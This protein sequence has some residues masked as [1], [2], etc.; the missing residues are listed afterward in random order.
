MT[1][2]LTRAAA[3][4]L[5]GALL[6]PAAALADW[7]PTGIA[8]EHNGINGPTEAGGPILTTPAGTTIAATI[9]GSSDVVRLTTLGSRVVRELPD[10][11]GSAH[12]AT[13]GRNGIAVAGTT[14]KRTTVIRFGSATGGPLATHTFPGRFTAATDVAGNA[15]GDLAVSMSFGGVWLRRAHT[16]TFRQVF[17]DPARGSGIHQLALGPR[18]DLMLLSKVSNRRSG[19]KLVVRYRTA[20]GTW[21]APRTLTT[22]TNE[23]GLNAS[24]ALDSAGRQL[25]AWRNGAKISFASALAGGAVSAP[26]TLADDPALA[27]AD[28]SSPNAFKAGSIYLISDLVKIA[29]AEDGTALVAWTARDGDRYVIRAADVRN[30]KLTTAQTLTAAGQQGA[31]MDV[32]VRPGGRAIVLAENADPAYQPPTPG[33]LAPTRSGHLAVA[34]VRP[35]GASAFGAAETVTDPSGTPAQYGKVAGIATNAALVWAATDPGYNSFAL[36]RRPLP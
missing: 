1:S 6:A 32:A 16:T 29:S 33:G 35:S 23:F 27:G 19:A 28:E 24:A 25:V 4:T 26:R 17:S 9:T 13:F 3:I 18:G 36:M 15:R 7:Q 22:T 8:W 34:A 10:T 20:R 31:L 30:G 12:L 14:S 2:K 11:L 21:R 5:A